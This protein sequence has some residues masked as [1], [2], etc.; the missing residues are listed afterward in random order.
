MLEDYLRW[1]RAILK[2]VDFPLSYVVE[3]REVRIEP[4]PRL[5]VSGMG[6]SGVV[7]DLLRDLS[8][9][10]GWDVEVIPVKDYF[11]KARDGFL[12]AVS[13]S[14]NTIETL[15]TV[16]YAKKKG[17][18][19]VAITTGGKLAQIGVP[20]IIVP[21]A[22]APR[23]AL[24]QL[25]TA[26]LNVVAKVYGIDVKIPDSLDPPDDALIH[27]LVQNFEKRPSVVA[28]ESMRGV[29]YRVKNEFNENSKI[30]PSVE[31]V[32]EAH[33]NWIEGSERPVVALTSPHIPKEHQERIKATLEIVGGVVYT[34]E[35]HPR[36]VLSFLRE[37]GIAS[38]KLAEK[39][40]VDPLATPRIDA[41]K[42]RLHA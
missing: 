30:E 17:M 22:S 20:T 3:G 12:I 24:P 11:L 13:Y 9:T 35:M 23:A 7:A 33:H 37:V 18:P 25:L 2:H 42:R 36:G 19:T 39:R 1:E 21:K 32:P 27:S 34:V 15:Y 8:L 26:A 40:G 14:G 6:G 4:A 16:E 28:P 41:L 10:W 29:A 5:Y 38:L 31:I